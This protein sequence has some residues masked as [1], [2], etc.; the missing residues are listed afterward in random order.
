MTNT[1]SNKLQNIVE[2]FQITFG[3]PAESTPTLPTLE[4][5]TNR[6][7]WGSIEEAVEQL[8]SISDD[9]ADFI[10]AVTKLHE[11]LDKAM[12][13]Q[14]GKPLI[15]DRTEKLVALADGLGDELWFLLG[16]CVESGI[17]IQPIIEI[18]KESNDSKLFTDENGDKYA[19][20]D[21]NGKIMKSDSFF[22]PESRIKVEIQRQINNS[23]TK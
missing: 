3:H 23:L 16:D 20:Q 22:A 14:L 13:K 1:Y 6:K 7:G 8:Y 19:K 9:K 10:N 18:I 17:D 11:Y 12:A 5:F 2:D 21:E 15:T 4:R